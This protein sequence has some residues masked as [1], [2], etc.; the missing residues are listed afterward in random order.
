MS[1]DKDNV[2]ALKHSSLRYFSSD[3]HKCMMINF[4]HNNQEATQK[5]EFLER[6]AVNIEHGGYF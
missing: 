3:K 1:I 6:K 2:N 4:L 5:L